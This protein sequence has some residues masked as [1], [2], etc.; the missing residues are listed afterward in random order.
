MSAFERGLVI[1]LKETSWSNRRNARHVVRSDATIRRS[2]Q[3]WVSHGRTKHQEGSGL[4]RKLT[5]PEGRSIVRAAFRAPYLSLF[6]FLCAT[7]A[8]VTA[9]IINRRL[10]KRGANSRRPLLRLQLTTM[11]LQ[12][13]LQWCRVHWSLTGKEL[14]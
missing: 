12:A 5:E 10:K 1:E 11:H 4:P 3:K 14:S 8:S 9:R 7:D 13:R 6:S 2:W